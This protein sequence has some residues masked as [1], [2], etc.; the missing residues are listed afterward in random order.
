[1]SK[2]PPFKN[3][4]C[5]LL[6]AAR[7]G[8]QVLGLA[9]AKSFGA[10]WLKEVFHED[11]ADPA[12]DLAS[13]PDIAKKSSF[14]NFRHQRLRE[15]NELSYPSEANQRALF[16]EYLN[17]LVDRFGQT[18]L[19]MDIKYNSWHHLNAYWSYFFDPPGLVKLVREYKIPVVHLVRENSFA[20]YCSVELA[21]KTG[22]WYSAVPIEQSAS[23]HIDVRHC[24]YR[25][26]MIEKTTEMFK[27]WF[28]GH[29]VYDL[30]YESM[31]GSD[32]FSPKAREIFV[33]IFGR[34]PRSPLEPEHKKV[35]PPLHT[36]IANSD[37]VRRHF[38]G[39][40][41]SDMIDRALAE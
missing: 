14:F 15:A 18:A 6:A 36:V 16:V 39:S 10:R 23:L 40:K 38:R 35:S 30:S 32:G 3:Q 19:L 7:S 2:A 27:R 41:Y 8:T 1:M 20:Q 29:R 12:V 11:V 33:N 22:I 24:E 28:D 13:E 21:T 31:I 17:Y 9:A 26:H 34:E 5:I 4:F 25:L 37:A